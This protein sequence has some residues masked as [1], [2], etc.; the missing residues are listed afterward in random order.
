MQKNSL[1]FLSSRGTGLNTDLKLVQSILTKC[2]INEEYEYRFFLK[3][4]KSPNPLAN[5]GFN[6]AKKEFCEEMTNVICSDASLSSDI[7][8][9]REPAVRLLFAVPYEYQFK[10]M[11]ALIKRNGERREWK[12]FRNF[13][14]IIPGSPFSRKLFEHSY[15]LTD[16]AMLDDL[17][18]PFVWE[19][20]QQESQNLKREQLKFY[21]PE[22]EGKKVF[23]ILLYGETRKRRWLDGF[24]IH[25]LIE[26]LGSDWFILTNQPDIMEETYDLDSEYAHSFGYVNRIMPVQDLLYVSDLMVTNNGRFASYFITRRKPVFCLGYRGNYFENYMRECHPGLFLDA[27]SKI[28]QIKIDDVEWSDD[29]QQFYGLMA[30]EEL[31][32][33]YDAVR[34]MLGFSE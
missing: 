17:C 2:C 3:N 16:I 32:C 15:A 34:N 23:S 33:P 13:T 8:N 24:D 5:Q 1:T 21:F 20:N 25:E 31:N 26:K 30:Y 7:K 27:A 12:T 9:L 14:H 18:M 29:L 11:L 28:L 19:I 6:R 10:N 4:E 22:M